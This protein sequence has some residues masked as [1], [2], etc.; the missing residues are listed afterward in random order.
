LEGIGE[1]FAQKIAE[2]ANGL[3]GGGWRALRGALH[4]ASSGC[5]EPL[6]GIGPRGEAN[7]FAACGARRSGRSPLCGK[8]LPLAP[9][10][11][12]HGA[13]PG[14]HCKSSQCVRKVLRQST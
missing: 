4:E 7:R 11:M 6:G 8:R 10:I 9:K 12:F 5:G 1:L 3:G 14:M 13:P 2:V